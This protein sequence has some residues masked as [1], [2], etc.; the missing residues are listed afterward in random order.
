MTKRIF[1]LS[2]WRQLGLIV[3]G[4]TFFTPCHAQ[5]ANLFDE[6]HARA[7]AQYLFNS[8]QYGLAA[9]E[10]ERVLY[11]Q[12]DCVA[13]QRHLLRSYLKGA[14]YHRGLHRTQQLYPRLR[15]M[16]SSVALLYGK[17]L[18]L[19][20]P[21][22]VPGYLSSPVLDDKARS[23]L[24]LS[25]ALLVQDWETAQTTYEQAKSSNASLLR[26]AKPISEISSLKR[27][28][29]WLAMGLSTVV[30]GLGR[31]YTNQWKD[32][33]ISLILIGG[34]SYA[35]YRNFSR[36]EGQNILGWTFA[37][38]ALGFYGGNLYGSFQSAHRF[39]HLQS[40]SITDE[41]YH[42]LLDDL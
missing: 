24:R 22:K 42:L 41:A 28:S 32:G 1:T 16:P 18:L 19:H 36:E 25:H 30:P 10:Y 11:F 17:M 9:T 40:Q 35:A 26:F 14:R 37:G 38:I 15:N 20:T 5:P 6:A 27:K 29:P 31:V 4:M 34:L 23:Y 39:N 7:Y 3:W 8:Q 2:I 12:P 13:V 33:L 21:R